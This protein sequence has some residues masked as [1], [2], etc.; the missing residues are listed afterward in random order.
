[1]THMTPADRI[2]HVLLAVEQ[3]PAGRVASYGLIAAIVGTGP[4]QVGSIMRQ[5][6]AAVA[7]WR[8]TSRDGDLPSPLLGAARTHWE[9]EGIALK[10]GGT[11]CRHAGACV[12]PGWLESAYRRA[13]AELTGA[14]DDSGPPAQ[15]SS[16]SC[17][18][19]APREAAM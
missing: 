12:D 10:T 15:R 19:T 14:G 13:V 2:E 5:Y 9:R 17:Q 16:T 3:I 4:R 7:W 18:G 8:V 6:G 11:G 1:M